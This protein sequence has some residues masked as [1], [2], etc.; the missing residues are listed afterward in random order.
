MVDVKI[1]SRS[2]PSSRTL[3][4]TTSFQTKFYHNIP[5]IYLEFNLISNRDGIDLICNLMNSHWLNAQY[6][7]V[8]TF[9]LWI[10]RYCIYPEKAQQGSNFFNSKFYHMNETYKKDVC[11][12]LIYIFNRLFGTINHEGSI[13]LEQKNYKP[14][15]L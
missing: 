10:D 5:L 8:H 14:Q 6:I 9:Y 13:F 11:L 2:C 12:R 15:I 3:L 4:S 7:I 1:H